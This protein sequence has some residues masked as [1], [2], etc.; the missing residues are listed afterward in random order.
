MHLKWDKYSD[1]PVV[2]KDKAFKKR[3]YK[4]IRW[5]FSKC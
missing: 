2:I 4:E 5:D 3:I 1:Q